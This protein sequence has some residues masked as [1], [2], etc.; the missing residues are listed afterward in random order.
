M[1]SLVPTRPIVIDT[2]EQTPWTF[3]DG[4]KTVRRGIHFGDYT[5]D[6]L[7]EIVAIE[8]KSA[9]DMIGCVG[10]SRGRF[11]KHL[12]G[13]ADL[14]FAHVIIECSMRALCETCSKTGVNV[15][16]LV[17][18]IVAWQA[19]TGVHFWTPDDRR[20]AAALAVRILFHS[21]KKWDQKL[22]QVGVGQNTPL[23]LVGEPTRLLSEAVDE[24]RGGSTLPPR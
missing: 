19:A 9:M 14:P 1:A 6:G 7:D 2:R 24:Y 22:A 5:L 11:E 21:E 4:I 20:F 16:S 18:T 23:H 8:R 12:Y 3:P 15:S 17:G 13:L 10:Q